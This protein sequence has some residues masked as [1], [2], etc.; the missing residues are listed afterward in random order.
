MDA[1]CHAWMHEMGVTVVPATAAAGIL[2]MAMKKAA[3]YGAREEGSEGNGI[4]WNDFL[5]IITALIL[6]GRV[7][8]E[9]SLQAF[10]PQRERKNYKIPLVCRELGVPCLSLG[11]YAKEQGKDFKF[12]PQPRGR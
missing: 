6:G 8:T 3:I 12:T 5:M 11:K 2:Q 7:I 1:L 4:G 10:S 9:E